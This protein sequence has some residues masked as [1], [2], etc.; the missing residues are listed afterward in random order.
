MV[1]NVQLD[2][3]EARAWHGFLSAH[4]SVVRDLN[5]AM[6]RDTG[7]S[8]SDHDVLSALRNTG[9]GSLRMSELAKAC[10]LSPSGLTR[11]I[12]DLTAAGFT[13]RVRS[14]LDK[15]GIV[16]Q[17]TPAGC[18]ALD[19]ARADHSENT[20]SRFLARLRP[21]ELELLVSIYER[22]S[23]PECAATADHAVDTPT[24]ST[25][26]G[27]VPTRTTPPFG[28]PTFEPFDI[29]TLVGTH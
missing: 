3:D 28:P 23:E 8:V 26:D 16:A 27:S 19:R 15:R 11:R 24:A 1:K 25:D 17:I 13:E 7:L 10:G 6:T 12:D 14:R 29:T 21:G 20:R 5:R 22:L 2:E 9:D 4:H 18:Y